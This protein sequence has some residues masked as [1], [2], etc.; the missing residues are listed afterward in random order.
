MPGKVKKGE[1]RSMNVFMAIGR[2]VRDAELRYT[3]DGNP[4]LTGRIAVDRGL[5]REQREAAQKNNQ[6]T[7]DFF[8]ITLFGRQAEAVAPYAK[9]GKM[10][11]VTGE[12]RIRPW[13]GQ[14]GTRRISVEVRVNR[15]QLLGSPAEANSQPA[16]GASQ[17][18]QAPAAEEATA[19]VGE[20]I[21]TEEA[22]EALGEVPF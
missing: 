15:L 13:E 8:D 7:A 18:A 20:E 11:G 6:P 10:V 22:D 19:D 9:K 17:A 4:I 14:D 5:S 3:R 16:N 1:V 21:A 2:L 12:L